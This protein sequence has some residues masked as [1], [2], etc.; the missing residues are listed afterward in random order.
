MAKPGTFGPSAEAIAEGEAIS[1]GKRALQSV[2]VG[3][4]PVAKKDP[5]PIAYVDEEREIAVQVRYST[6]I[7]RPNERI[8]DQRLLDLAKHHNIALRY[9]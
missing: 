8:T 5:T 7:F 1:Q 4:Q 6:V 2:P 3:E 9:K